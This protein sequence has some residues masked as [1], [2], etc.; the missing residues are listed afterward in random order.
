MTI[1][2]FKNFSHALLIGIA[3]LTVSQVFA[4]EK[5]KPLAN[6]V[7]KKEC[8]DLP[9]SEWLSE[10]EFKVLMRYRGYKDFKL[11]IV[12]QSCYEIY[13][14]DAKND[15]VEAYFNPSNAKLNRANT[16][17]I[18]PING[19]TNSSTAKAIQQAVPAK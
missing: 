15:L 11:K 2:R 9:T 3:A 12:Y 6:P 18:A 10:E 16:I 5:S 13:G 7:V 4:E 17:K 14:Y 8:T 1:A 19:N